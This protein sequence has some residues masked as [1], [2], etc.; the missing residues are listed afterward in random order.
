MCTVLWTLQSF[1]PGKHHLSDTLPPWLC[2]GS[3]WLV[4]RGQRWNLGDITV[5]TLSSCLWPLQ[6]LP[7]CPSRNAP[8]Q[9]AALMFSM[10]WTSPQDVHVCTT[11]GLL[12]I[13]NFDL[14]VFFFSLRSTSSKT[15]WRC[16]LSASR[17][18]LQSDKYCSPGTRCADSGQLMACAS[19]INSL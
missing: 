12:L 10:F 19:L 2:S 4:G 5:V 8:H 13:S 16:G 9:M 15:W 3:L 6:S 11:H 17:L 1:K 18:L 14:Q 7:W